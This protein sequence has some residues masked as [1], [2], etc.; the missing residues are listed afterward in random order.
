MKL[1]KLVLPLALALVATLASTTGCKHGFNGDITKLPGHRVKPIG[2]ND[3][4]PNTLP[5][6][7]QLPG[8]Q[9][10]G[11]LTPGGDQTI[12]GTGRN[13]QIGGGELPSNWDPALMNQDREKLAGST[14]HFK[15][16]SAVVQDNEQA[17]VAN[18]GQALSADLTAKLLIEGHCDERGTEE[19]N[20]ALGERRALA[21]REALAR[22]GV[23]PL[24]IRTISYGKDQPVDPG[25]NEAAWAKNRRG[26]FIWC[27]PKGPVQ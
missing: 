1:N 9:P 12:P 21:L 20:R 3:N 11:G 8:G 23:D 26:Q 27:T 22:I 10:L 7:G 18:V 4:P 16:D 25:H 19:Y 6:G 15:Y 2:E 17:N 13:T 24:R 14:V 5:P